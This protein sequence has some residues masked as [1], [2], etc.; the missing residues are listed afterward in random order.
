MSAGPDAEVVISEEHNLRISSNTAGS[1]GGGIALDS[2]AKLRIKPASCPCKTSSLGDGVCNLACMRRECNWYECA[3]ESMCAGS[4]AHT[5]R[6]RA[7]AHVHKYAYVD[8]SF[9]L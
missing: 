6:T 1:H 4:H 9:N 3:Y 8:A 2:L 7:Q 5:R